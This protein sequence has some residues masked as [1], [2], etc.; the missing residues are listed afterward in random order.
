M[1][2][3]KKALDKSR[4]HKRRNLLQKARVEIVADADHPFEKIEY[5]QTH[6]IDLPNFINASAVI[7]VWSS[8]RLRSLSS[9]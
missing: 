3:I 8:V 1:D 2:R 5:S 9:V 7:A 4:S 6:R